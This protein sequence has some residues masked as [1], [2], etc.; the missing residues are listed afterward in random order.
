VA[1]VSTI[2]R[3]NLSDLPGI[4]RVCRETGP[5]SVNPDLL[6]H[7]YAGPYIVNEPELSRVVASDTG[8]EGYVLACSDTREFEGWCEAHWWPELRA[9]YPIGGGHPLD[10]WMTRLLHEPPHSPDVVV[11][12]HPAHL[13]TDLLPSAQG[14]GLG[15]ALIEW[16][17]EELAERGVA[18]VHL[19]VSADN[20]GAIAFYQRLGFETV[21]VEADTVWMGRLLR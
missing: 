21:L 14:R 17:C 6:G 16:L 2:R 3:P 20:A 9:Q 10:E 1:R 7:L 5:A 12:A 15:R 4:Y 8:I 13:H 11:A 19:G 18:G